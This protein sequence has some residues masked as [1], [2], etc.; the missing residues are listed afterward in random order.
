VSDP[1]R[2]ID[3]I[4]RMLTSGGAVVVVE[5]AWEKFDP[6]TAEWCF[7]RLGPD[8]EAGWLH[9]RRDEWLA[10]GHDWSTYLR[11]WAKREGLHRGDE[12]VRLLDARLDRHL[13][14]DGPYFF[15][16]LADTA[17]SLV[18]GAGLEPAR[19]LGGHLILSR[20]CG[21]RPISVGLSRSCLP[22]L[23]VVLIVY[24][25]SA[26]LGSSRCHSCCHLATS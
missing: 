24:G 15:S 2:V 1:V 14:T 3:R 6:Q 22:G 10:S 8:D 21:S 11:D 12:L 13:F 5:W 7:E 4:I 23:F 25:I 26:C 17:I 19:P 18:P 20:P 9:R 16:D